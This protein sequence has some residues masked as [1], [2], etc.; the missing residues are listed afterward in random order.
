[1]IQS[2]KSAINIDA[3]LTKTDLDDFLAVNIVLLSFF[4]HSSILNYYHM[5][6]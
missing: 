6:N 3:K 5:L 1:M 4:M 2:R